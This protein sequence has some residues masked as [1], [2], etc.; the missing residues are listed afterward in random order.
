MAHRHFQK[1]RWSGGFPAYLPLGGTVR[2]RGRC[3]RVQGSTAQHEGA[4]QGPAGR[5]F[6]CQGPSP[7]YPCRSPGTGRARGAL[8]SA[9]R[10]STA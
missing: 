1:L 5:S 6:T 2:W 9:P 7:E 10:M 4:A 8:C 3:G